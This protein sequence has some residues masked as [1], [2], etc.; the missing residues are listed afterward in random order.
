MPKVTPEELRKTWRTLSNLLYHQQDIAGPSNDFSNRD[1]AIWS[2]WAKK[3]E[4]ALDAANKRIAELKAQL[5]ER[6]CR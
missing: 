6:S 5:K 3:T 2:A 4:E 1:F